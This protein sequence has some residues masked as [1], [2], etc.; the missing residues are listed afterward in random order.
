VIFILSKFLRSIG[1]W[2]RIQLNAQNI[3]NFVD[4]KSRRRKAKEG[5]QK[6]INNTIK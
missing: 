1:S 6:T 5:K 4:G 2:N 3:I